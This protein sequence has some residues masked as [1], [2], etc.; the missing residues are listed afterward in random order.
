MLGSSSYSSEE[1]HQ[2]HKQSSP[3]DLPLHPPPSF[4]DYHHNLI[5]STTNT[6]TN[7]TNNSSSVPSSS[8]IVP[9]TIITNHFPFIHPRQLL[10][11]CAELLSRSE[12][13]SVHRLLTLLSTDFASQ[14]GDATE[15]LVF[16]FIKALNQ[17]LNRCNNAIVSHDLTLSPIP[18]PPLIR[19]RSYSSY[20]SLNQVTPFIRFTHLTA[21]QAILESMEGFSLIHILDMDIMHGVQWPPFLQAIKERS[22]TLGRIS[23]RIRITGAG[24]DPTHLEKTGS[25]LR[26]FAESLGLEFEFHELVLQDCDEFDHTEAVT[27]A[28]MI[29]S[30]DQVEEGVA[31]NCGDYLHRLLKE[32]DTRSLRRFLSRMKSLNPRVLTIG[33]IEADHNHPLFLRRFVDALEHYGAMFESLEATIPPQSKERAAVEEGWLGEEIRDVIG[34]EG[35]RRRERHQKYESWEVVLRSSGFK[36]LGLSPF[37]VSQ[38]K[39]LLRLHYP[40]EGYQL[41]V[42][43]SN[44][45]LLGWKNCP[46]YSVSSWH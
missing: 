16:Y 5:P 35:D 26:K 3:L 20:L 27:Q 33:E 31:I 25:R 29:R 4:L 18:R 11:T 6:N 15:R 13:T 22:I 42:L 34:E 39:L 45:L 37:S 2:D 28:I 30:C 1:D 36:S 38:A 19:T 32:Y 40:S 24:P 21:N 23:P 46:L 44:C 8:V 14:S 7:T 10:V 12:F 43:N 17:R 41:Q 9:S